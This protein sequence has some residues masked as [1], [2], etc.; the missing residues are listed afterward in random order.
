MSHFGSSQDGPEEG[1]TSDGGMNGRRETWSGGDALRVCRVDGRL[2]MRGA[3]SG[4]DRKCCEEILYQHEREG[5]SHG[6]IR[7]QLSK[8]GPPASNFRI[9]KKAREL[10]D[11]THQP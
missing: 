6:E 10:A 9:Y 2:G 4:R 5:V 7:F 11:A 1:E 3:K 8:R